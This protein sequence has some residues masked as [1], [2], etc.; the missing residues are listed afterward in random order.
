[1]TT[2]ATAPQNTDELGPVVALNEAAKGLFQRSFEINL[3]ALDAI[4][5]SKRSGGALRGFDEVSTQ[6]R[7]WSRELHAMVDGLGA[8]GREAV[9]LA[10]R[11]LVERRRGRLIAAAARGSRAVGAAQQLAVVERRLEER[12]RDLAGMRRRIISKIDDLDQIGLMACVLSRSA[13]IEATAA[14]GAERE[15]LNHVSRDFY[16]KSEEVVAIVQSLGKSLRKA[17]QS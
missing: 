4:V 2:T 8:L 3:R 15:Q 7:T 14:S 13:L 5:Q 1:M 6:I 16:A 10:S 11:F 9:G 12:Q 17:Q